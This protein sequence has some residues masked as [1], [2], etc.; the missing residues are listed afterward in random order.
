MSTKTIQI[1]KTTSLLLN[2]GQV[3]AAATAARGFA[4]RSRPFLSRSFMSNKRR[5][6]SGTKN[7]S[8]IT[9]ITKNPNSNTNEEVVNAI[10]PMGN[11]IFPLQQQQQQQRQLQRLPRLP[12]LLSS[13]S[14]LKNIVNK[15]S[16]IS[17][18]HSR[19][20]VHFLTNNNN[21]NYNKFTTPNKN[22]YQYSTFFTN[23]NKSSLKLHKKPSFPFTICPNFGFHF[24]FFSSSFRFLNSFNSKNSSSSLLLSSNYFNPKRIF[25]SP[26]PTTYFQ[27]KRFFFSFF[28]SSSNSTK[29]KTETM[30]KAPIAKSFYDLKPLD[31]KGQP[32]DFEQLRGKVVIIVNVA[33][34]CGFTP[35]YK[36]LEALYKEKN[37][38]GLEIIGFPCNQFG[39]QEPGTDEEITQYCQLN[40]GVTFPILKKI[41]VNGDDADAVYRYLKNQK[42]GLMGIKGIKWNFEKFIIDKNGNV[43]ERFA[44]TKTPKELTKYIDKYLKA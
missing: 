29:T 3:S 13:S 16:C 11:S 2:H 12:F 14:S 24:R 27:S 38:A 36:D 4:L 33:S 9:I 41:D 17:F 19:R 40:Y 34:K 18:S 23:L 31:K 44:S 6:C 21:N 32:F 42:S 30:P 5:S 15:S 35:Q 39:H 22:Y 7:D 8:I 43:V 20:E 1:K 10:I 25:N 26:S 28:S 37:S